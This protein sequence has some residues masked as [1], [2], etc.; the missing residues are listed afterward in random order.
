MKPFL[1]SAAFIGLTAMVH[2]ASATAIAGPV[3]NTAIVF[4]TPWFGS[5]KGIEND[6]VTSPAGIVFGQSSYT[7]TTTKTT[8]GDASLDFSQTISD[9]SASIWGIA[10]A[11]SDGY[12]FGTYGLSVTLTL[13]NLSGIDFDFLVFRTDYSAFNPGGPAVGAK[14][15]NVNTEFARFSSSQSGQGISDSHSC[16]TRSPG[17]S[18]F[19]FIPP[20]GA[21]CGVSSPDSSLGDFTL[22]DFDNGE[23]LTKTFNL[24]L[25]LEVSSVP[26]PATLALVGAGLMALGY[27]RR[28][29]LIS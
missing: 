26:E 12:A 20:L 1:L 8:I 21:E 27:T 16:D 17:G 11:N 5:A 9:R 24:S 14:V 29:R 13:T 4:S 28:R 7:V 3:R 25:L 23:T 19:N 15:D 18:Y 22:L 2:E 6:F 10:I